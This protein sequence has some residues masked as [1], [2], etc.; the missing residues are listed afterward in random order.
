MKNI[1]K[2]KVKKA[3]RDYESFNEAYRLLRTNLQYSFTGDKYG[4]CILITSSEQGDG[5]STTSYNLSR[6]LS[7]LGKKVLIIDIDIRKP[8]QHKKFNTSNIFGLTDILAGECSI[9]KA[10]Q[11]IS[12]KLDLIT[13]GKNVPTVSELISSKEFKIILADLKKEYEYIII[14]SA[15]INVVSDAI[16]ILEDV[17]GIILVAMYRKTKKRSIQRVCKKIT[18]ANGKILGVVFNG[19]ESNSNSYYYYYYQNNYYYQKGKKSGK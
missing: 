19:I 18:Q 1:F 10:K 4:K 13:S 9:D 8:T 16:G 14:D 2:N 12:E 5:K 6:K 15:P 11:I 3:K 17:D 7:D